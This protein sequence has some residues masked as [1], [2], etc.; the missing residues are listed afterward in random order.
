MVDILSYPACL[1]LIIFNKINTSRS[2]NV[3]VCEIIFKVNIP[4]NS[5]VIIFYQNMSINCKR[6]TVFIFSHL[7]LGI[8]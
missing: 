3:S 2:I 5:Q 4:R 7:F 1:E 6:E 8:L